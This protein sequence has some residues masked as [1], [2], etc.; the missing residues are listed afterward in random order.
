MNEYPMADQAPRDALKAYGA[1]TYELARFSV[2]E[3]ARHLKE[4]GGER[5]VPNLIAK[6]IRDLIREE[7]GPRAPDT[8]DE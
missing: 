5:G 2:L 1:P 7:P 4:Y 8:D 6:K 3:V